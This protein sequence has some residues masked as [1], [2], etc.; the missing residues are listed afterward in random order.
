MRRIYSIGGNLYYNGT[1]GN[2]Y[3]DY[4]G[5]GS[6]IIE[7]ASSTPTGEDLYPFGRIIDLMP[8]QIINSS[9]EGDAHEIDLADT[10][11]LWFP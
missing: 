4:G 1:T 6:Y 9:V 8:P 5:T 7:D 2:Y 11:V 10:P 3:D